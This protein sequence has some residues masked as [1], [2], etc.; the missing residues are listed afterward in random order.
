MALILITKIIEQTL[1]NSIKIKLPKK[2]FQTKFVEV[3]TIVI[4]NMQRN[5]DPRP[6]WI[7]F[8]T[9]FFYVRL[10][11]TRLDLFRV[12]LGIIEK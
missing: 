12:I 10:Y 8:Y 11:F 7:T 5:I 9:S 6:N 1:P 3:D 2:Y 4:K